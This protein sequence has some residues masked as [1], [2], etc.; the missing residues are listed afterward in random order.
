MGDILLVRKKKKKEERID[1]IKNGD[2]KLPTVV[3]QEGGYFLE[4]VPLAVTS[5]LKGSQKKANPKL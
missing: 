5:F 1:K 4:K 3:I 2:I